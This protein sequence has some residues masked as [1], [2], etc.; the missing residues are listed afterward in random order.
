MEK[1]IYI[2]GHKNPDADAICSA[3]GYAAFKRANSSGDQHWQAVRCGNSNARIDAILRRLNLS[4]PPFL[5]DVTPRLA[6]VMIPAHKALT[7]SPDTTCAEALEIIDDHDVRALPVLDAERRISGMVSVFK[8]GE[9]FVPKPAQ[10]RNMR[11]V[12]TSIEN[13][14]RAL[15]AETLSAADAERVEELYVRVGA[16]DIRSFGRFTAE[17]KVAAKQS[18]IVVGDRWD[19]Q[20]KS[21]KIGVRL[22]VITGDLEVEEDIIQHAREKG[23]NLIVSPYDSA[24]TSWVI[25]SATRLEGLVESE[26]Q[27]FKADEP[28]SEVR[29]Q[30]A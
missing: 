29:R 20:E 8:L 7:V 9:F 26:V 12:V 16:M 22:L 11:R 15:K 13:I 19:I 21:L 23:I 4:L 1:P 14:T 30:L 3:I 28:L 24:T 18:I 25:R 10:T 17:E 27:C 6:D 2:V 5:G